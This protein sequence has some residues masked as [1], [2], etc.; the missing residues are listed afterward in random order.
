VLWV[1]M[2]LGEYLESQTAFTMAILSP[3][4]CLQAPA[5]SDSNYV[6]LPANIGPKMRRTRCCTTASSNPQPSSSDNNEDGAPLTLLDPSQG[7]V[8][9]STASAI[10]PARVQSIAFA[11]I[12]S[13]RGETGAS[14][15]S[16]S[17]A[18]APRPPAV[19]CSPRPTPGAA[20]VF[21]VVRGLG[22]HVPGEGGPPGTSGARTV[23]VPGWHSVSWIVSLVQ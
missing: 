19:G 12:R 13:K 6:V 4:H 2:A 8:W 15:A 7:S 9:C 3:P 18:G 10:G 16:P 22:A 21:G 11:S 5:A 1:T 23:G 20:A 14:Q 17:V